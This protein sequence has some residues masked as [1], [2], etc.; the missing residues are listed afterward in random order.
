MMRLFVSSVQKEFA[1]ERALLKRCIARNPAYRRL[2]DTFVF[3]LDAVAADR[4]ADEV[5]LAELA[6]CDIYIGLV[7]NEY[8]REDASGVSPTER[9]FD[10]ATRLGLPRLVFVLDRDPPGRHPKEAAFLSKISAS[11]VRAKCRDSAELMVEIYAA[12]DGLLVE[13]GAYRLGP[14]EA[15]PCEGAALQDISRAKIREFL[16]AAKEKRNLP[17]ALGTPVDKVLA[18]FHLLDSEG[19]LLNA[20]ILLFGRNPQARFPT[21]FVKCVQWPTSVR[22]K[23]IKDHRIAM[24]TLSEMADSA[25][26][27]VLDKLEHRIGT[28]DTGEGAVVPTGYDIPRSVVAEAIIN[29]IAHRD[30]SNTGSVQVEL[31]PDKLVVMSPG[32]PHPLTDVSSLDKPHPSYPVNPLIADVL[33]QS[34]HIERL[35]TGLEDLFRS[36]REAKLPR[37]IVEVFPGEFRLTVFRD[38]QAGG[39][40]L[41]AINET[42]SETISETINETIKRRPGIS[43]L[44]L[45]DTIG[46][47]RAS[48]ARAVSALKQRGLIE[49]RGSKKTGGYHPLAVFRDVQVGLRHSDAINETINETIIEAIKRRPGISLLDLT[50]TIGKSRAS[51]ARAVSALKQ[52]GL[53]E[54]RGSK[55]TGGYYPLFPPSGETPS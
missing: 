54:Y 6:D 40:K 52:R 38:V 15:S 4:R 10:E 36:C 46:K 37:P 49:Y 44:D 8:G 47:S 25:T 53:I 48:V 5:Y 19:G 16:R 45:T 41:D 31:F 26:D 33:Y 32:K 30:Y 23:P 50:D 42:I 29:G 1:A 3:E 12:L 20:A 2:F 27:F 34:G 24:G 51:V 55:K 18:H 17:L 13:R 7:G 11:L 22:G 14:F 39:Q 35:G 9:E 43:L 28:R 21:S